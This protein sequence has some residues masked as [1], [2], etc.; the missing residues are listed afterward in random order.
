MKTLFVFN[1][2][3]PYKV[4]VFNEL[5]K[6][7][8]IQVVFEREKAKD[9]PASF[10]ASNKY[11]FPVVFLKGGEFSNENTF[12]GKLK[13]YLKK[14]HQE[15]DLI[16]MNGYSTIAEMRTIRYLIK[17]HIPYVLQINGGI[18]KKDK[19]WKKKLKTYFISHAQNYLSPCLEA[20]EYLLYYG[21][22]KENILHYPYGN[23]FDN[24][25]I[26]KPL[27]SEEKETIRKKWNLPK[28]KLFVNASQFIERKNNLQLISIFKNREENLLLIGSGNEKEKYQ[29]F[30]N[31]NNIQNIQL[32][33]FLKKDELFE[34]LKG[35]DAFITLSY[36][37][38]F[39]HTT[40]EAMANGLPVISSDRVISSRDIIKN[41]K[42]GYLVD[43]NK[44]SDI[45]NAVQS[46]DGCSSLEAIN[47]A[48]ANTIEKSAE[49]LNQIIQE[50]T[51]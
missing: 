22:K 29:K 17:H 21:A 33:D 16:V 46:I 19:S 41:G 23:Y 37:D 45:I 1:H 31:D 36:E 5:T 38:I 11:N 18:I 8:D 34:V 28:G 20:D 35:C 30:I 42:N 48:K 44:E 32:M 15:Y 49:R 43:I 39:G 3:A 14:H 27:N 10:Y 9:R 40:L 2:P 7:T 51:K 47:T 50:L 6:L 24:E 25:I 26:N 4:H 13:K 12:T